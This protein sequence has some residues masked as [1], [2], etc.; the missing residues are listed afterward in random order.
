MANAEFQ[1]ELEKMYKE[2]PLIA[3]SKKKT[4]NEL[5]YVLR[6]DK[7]NDYNISVIEDGAYSFIPSVK[8]CFIPTRTLVKHVKEVKYDGH[9][10]GCDEICLTVVLGK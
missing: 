5:F 1:I 8:E 2:F 6:M 10:D 7:A 4:A 9:V 3:M